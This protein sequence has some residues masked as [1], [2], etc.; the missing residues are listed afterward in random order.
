MLSI[1]IYILHYI[2][3]HT[4]KVNGDHCVILRYKTFFMRIVFLIKFM[5]MIVRKSITATA[6]KL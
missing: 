4:I 1:F 5:R 6:L 3:V 2:L